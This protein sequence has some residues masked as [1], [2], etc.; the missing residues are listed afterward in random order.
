MLLV[1]LSKISKLLYIIYNFWADDKNYNI[2][3]KLKAI[4]EVVY[5]INFFV[6][7]FTN[8]LERD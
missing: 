5:M 2:W 8:S 4:C 7:L 3:C 1:W 6:Q